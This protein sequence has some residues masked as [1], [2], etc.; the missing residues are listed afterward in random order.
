[1]TKK[2]KEFNEHDKSYCCIEGV[3]IFGESGQSYCSKCKKV[4]SK[5]TGA[6]RLK[7]ISNFWYNNI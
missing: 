6:D 7:A 3:V 4:V 1:M 2:S 5:K